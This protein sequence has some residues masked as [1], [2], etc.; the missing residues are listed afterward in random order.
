MEKHENL[1]EISELRKPVNLNAIAVEQYKQFFVVRQILS[2]K[3]ECQ[4][5]FLNAMNNV[6]VSSINRSNLIQ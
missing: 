1:N 4:Y 6:D 5:I 2:R 3:L